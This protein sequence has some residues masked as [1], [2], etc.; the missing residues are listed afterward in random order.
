ML[1][2]KLH[3]QL[4]SKEHFHSLSNYFHRRSCFGYFLQFSY[5]WTN[6]V[7]VL[8]LVLEKNGF[9]D[10]VYF[11]TI[12]LL[13]Y[14]LIVNGSTI[15]CL[16]FACDKNLF[17]SVAFHFSSLAKSCDPCLVSKVWHVDIFTR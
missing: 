14:I 7:K 10:H 16:L 8:F 12:T 5:P 17:A 6:F 15:F 4:K 9:K 13:W 1:N 3:T 11:K 2:T